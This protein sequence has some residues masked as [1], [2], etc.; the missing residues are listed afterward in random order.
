MYFTRCNKVFVLYCLI[1]NKAETALIGHPK[2]LKNI[3]STNA[4][5]LLLNN[6]LLYSTVR[7]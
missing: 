5:G 7:K 6:R 3:G 4:P 1:E 2:S